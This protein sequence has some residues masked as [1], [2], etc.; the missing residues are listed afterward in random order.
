MLLMLIGATALLLAGCGGGEEYPVPASEAFSTL[1]GMSYT[2]VLSS[3]PPGLQNVSV[4]FETLP[5]ENAVRWSY[6]HDG[7][8]LAQIVATV[9]P[10]GDAASEVTI[11]YIEGS[12]PDGNWSNGKARRQIKSGVKRLVAEAVDAKM[13]NREFDMALRDQVN[14]EVYVAMMGTMMTDAS[15]AMDK[16][17]KNPRTG[18]R[19]THGPKKV[20]T[21]PYNKAAPTTDLSKFN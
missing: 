3:M 10:S 13:E 4:S 7:E 1:S 8:D 11:D 5:A 20:F 6:S 2:P 16:V 9:D 18:P 14:T 19:R 15:A 12:A 21:D 17:A